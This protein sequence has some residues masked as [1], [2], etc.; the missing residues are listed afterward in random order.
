MLEDEL[1]L[2]SQ[3]VEGIEQEVWGILIAYNLVRVEIS[4]IAKEAKVSPLRISFVMAL[5]DTQDELMWCAIASPGSIPQKLRAM[6]ERVKRYILPE[7]KKR[8]K[9]RTVC[10]SKTRYPVR[11]KHV[12]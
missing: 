11:S 1:L 4:L 2:R 5:R 10:M 3:S 9:S 6:R 8:P 12:K 7:L